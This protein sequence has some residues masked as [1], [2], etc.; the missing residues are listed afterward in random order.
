MALMQQVSM[1]RKMATEIMSEG[2]VKQQWKVMMAKEDLGDFYL[3]LRILWV[4][5]LLKTYAWFL[6]CF[7]IIKLC[8]AM[9]SN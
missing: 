5:Q 4:H 8:A 2:H 3:Y 9:L 7:H 6:F 1:R